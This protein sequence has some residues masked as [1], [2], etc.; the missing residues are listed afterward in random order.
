MTAPPAQQHPVTVHVFT[1]RFSSTPLG[2]RLAR[3]LAL[4]QLHTWGIPHGSDASDRAAAVVAELAANAVTHGRVPGRDFELRLSL[5][6]G[7]L[8]I[9][10]TDTRAERH[11][12]GPGAIRP[13][14][15]LDDGGRGLPLVGALADRWQ[16]LDRD[17]PGKTVLAEIDLPRWLS[18]VRLLPAREPG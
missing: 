1:Q 11:P 17:P 4:N 16:V 10:V 2:A 15:P 14:S 18:L 7:S 12:P 5:P 6:T 9:E 8:R 3:H 13:T